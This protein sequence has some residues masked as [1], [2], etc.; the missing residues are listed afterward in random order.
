MFAR[1]RGRA[2][3]AWLPLI[4]MLFA[5]LAM[6]AYACA[7]PGRA[8][9]QH[10]AG[11]RTGAAMG[12]DLPCHER[13]APAALGDASYLCWKHCHGFDQ[14][15]DRGDLPAPGPILTALYPLPAVAHSTGH[16][17][18]RADPH[19]PRSISPPLSISLCCLRN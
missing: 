6:A 5:Q 2:L 9:V 14:S 13:G 4:A 18:P 3:W 15:A 8:V 17:P 12:A 19:L 11:S 7:G 16:V 10:P 1:K